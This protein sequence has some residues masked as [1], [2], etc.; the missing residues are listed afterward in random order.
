MKI[1]VELNKLI[2]SARNNHLEGIKV[3]NNHLT[4]Q[5]FIDEYLETMT[6]ADFEDFQD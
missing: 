4:K 1:L 6:H 3:V 2:S 5:E